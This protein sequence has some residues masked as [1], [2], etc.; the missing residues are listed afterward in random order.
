MSLNY[1]STDIL[2]T[3]NT[4]NEFPHTSSLKQACTK[5]NKPAWNSKH[6]FNTAH[7]YLML[8]HFFLWIQEYKI[9]HYSYY[10]G[11]EGVGEEEPNQ[12]PP[13]VRMK[14]FSALSKWA[15]SKYNVS[16]INP[17]GN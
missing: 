4:G 5:H 11:G 10:S 13:K 1:F 7:A 6:L 12:N 2:A 9:K 16:E 8:T 14:T 3:W 15:P 17:T